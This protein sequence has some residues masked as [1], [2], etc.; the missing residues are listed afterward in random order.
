MRR[1]KYAERLH[2]AISRSHP[3]MVLLIGKY[4]RSAAKHAAVRDDD[5]PRSH[6]G[7]RA[8][9]ADSTARLFSAAS[10]RGSVRSRSG[11]LISDK[12]LFFH[13]SEAENS[14]RRDSSICDHSNAMLL[15]ARP[16]TT[17]CFHMPRSARRTWR[18]RGTKRIAGFAAGNICSAGSSPAC[19]KRLRWLR[20]SRHAARRGAWSGNATAGR[21]FFSFITA[22]IPFRRQ[23]PD[24]ARA[25]IYRVE[26]LDTKPAIALHGAPICG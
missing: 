10:L 14:P 21:N 6:R 12:F 4:Q 17:C 2:G 16:G 8:G 3:G 18:A 25:L 9:R 15:R 19:A 24:R 26:R 22:S 23:T 5:A 20:F 13:A 1:S 7:G 11:S